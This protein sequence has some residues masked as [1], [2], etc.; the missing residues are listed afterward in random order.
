MIK[1]ENVYK[2]FGKL[3]VLDNINL[4]IEKGEFAVIWGPSGC[5]KSTLLKIISSLEKPTK[6]NVVIGKNKVSSFIFQDIALFDWRNVEDNISFG[7]EIKKGK[8]KK[9][10]IK[11]MIDFVGLNGFEKYYPFE[12]SGG[13][14]Q[15]VALARALAVEPENI[16]MD[17]PFSSLDA[18]T[19]KKMR[20]E[21]IKI[22]DKTKKTIV[23]VTH[24][25]E[26]AL[27]LADKIIVLSKRPAKII[28]EYKIKIPREKRMNNQELFKLREEITKKLY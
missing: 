12:I 9:N 19:Q 3:E 21:L 4:K 22:W 17:E 20:E 13:M 18:I 15:K 23:F 25:I 6:G 24:N 16:L 26:E 1:L 27:F 2:S 28:G 10:K 14:K 8:E 5:G 11:K 7:L